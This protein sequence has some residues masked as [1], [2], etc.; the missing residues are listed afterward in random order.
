METQKVIL[1]DV[2]LMRYSDALVLQRE[3]FTQYISGG[4]DMGSVGTL[5]LVEHP[6]VYT[7]GKSGAQENLLIGSGM[8]QR[9]GAEY[10]KSDRGGDITYHG[11]GQLVG[12]PILDLERVGLGGRLGGRLGGE[13]G[14]GLGGGLREYIWRLEEAIITTIREFGIVGGRIHGA[15]GVWAQGGEDNVEE[16]YCKKIAAIGVK[17]SRGVTMHGFALNVNTDLSYFQHINPCG[18]TDR[19]VTSLEQELGEGVDMKMVKETFARAFEQQFSV[20]LETEKNKGE[21]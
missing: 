2:G 15:T 20:Q 1:K 4:G 11:P 7:L 6:H 19:G 16:G 17:A 5:I 8:L 10:H 12:Y 18:F 13:L 14:G 21:F 9:I 3:L